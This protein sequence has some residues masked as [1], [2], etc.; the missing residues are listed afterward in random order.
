MTKTTSEIVSIVIVISVDLSGNFQF[1]LYPNIASIISSFLLFELGP[2][3]HHQT[4]LFYDF[5]F[6]KATKKLDENE[7]LMVSDLWSCS[8]N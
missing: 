3:T 4:V 6:L 8:L 1:E 7:L 5:S 2:D